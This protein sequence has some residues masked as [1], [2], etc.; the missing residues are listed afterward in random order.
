M[1]LN[2]IGNLKRLNENLNL[3]RLSCADR[4]TVPWITH[5]VT[6]AKSSNVKYSIEQTKE[7][8]KQTNELLNARLILINWHELFLCAL[9]II[10]SVSHNKSGKNRF[11]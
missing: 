10:D 1:F 6:A 4:K 11:D 2:L 3:N 8:N 9:W 5:R 7:E